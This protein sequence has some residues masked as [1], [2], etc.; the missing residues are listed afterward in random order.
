[1]RLTLRELTDADHPVLFEHQRD[2]E[3]AKMAAVPI[4]EWQ[5]YLE[6]RRQ[7]LADPEVVLRAIEIDG[8]LVG[9]IVSFPIDGVRAVGYRIGREFWG[10]GIATA[11]LRGFLRMIPD[12]PLHAHVAVH[13]GGSLRV[14]EKVGFQP[15]GE[16][17]VD[18]ADGV[19]LQTMV[20]R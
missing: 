11:A 13:N 16:P 19:L 2:P 8:V 5:P 9:D 18:E 12:R 6:R 3:S 10:R 17:A 4:R 15:E 7:T 20:L 14:L 1:M